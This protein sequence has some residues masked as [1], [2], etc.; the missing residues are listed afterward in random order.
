MEDLPR[1]HVKDWETGKMRPMN[2]LEYQSLCDCQ[3]RL[4]KQE[5]RR[6]EQL[7]KLI[8]EQQEVIKIYEQIDSMRRMP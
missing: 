8:E 3:L 5:H 6:I 2:E 4:L 1:F 7:L